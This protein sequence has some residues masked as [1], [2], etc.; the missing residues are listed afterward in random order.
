[1]NRLLV[2]LLLGGALAA[3]GGGKSNPESLCTLEVPPPAACSTACDPSGLDTCP[4]GFFCASTGKCDAQCTPTGGQCGSGNECNSNGQC[5]PAGQGCEGRGCDVADCMSMG[6]DPTTLTGT[7]L[8]PN[9]MLPLYGISVYVPAKDPG[10]FMAGVQCGSCANAFPGGSV[11]QTTTD[12]HG[13]FTLTNVPTGTDVPLIITTGKWRRIIKVSNIASCTSQAITQTDTR[14]PASSDDMTPNTTQ[15]DMPKI[16]ISTGEADEIECLMRRLGFADK[17]ITTDQQGGHIHLFTDTD[18]IG[19]DKNGNNV[20][21]AGTSSFASGFAGGTGNLSN[22]KTLWGTATDPGK[23]NNYDIVILSCEGG[24]YVV[25][26]PQEAMNHLKAYA[27]AGGRV[28]LSHWHN[29]WMEGNTQATSVGHATIKPDVWTSIA[30]FDDG[31]TKSDLNPNNIGPITDVIDTVHNPKGSAFVT[32]MDLVQTNSPMGLVTIQAKTGKHTAV[33]VDPAKG[34]QW[35]YYQ[36]DATTQ[37]TQ[38]LQFTTPNEADAGARCG[39]VVF[40]DMHVSGNP[41]PP[42]A[43]YPNECG[44]DPLSDQEKALAF[45]FF[46]ISSCVGQ[47]F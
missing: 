27:D 44:T 39:K 21:G 4:T 36:N 16:A 7:V 2:G 13:N 1:M 34:E 24:Q 15:I 47:I 28:F 40:S 11:T 3:C 31:V 25:T 37:W 42:I 6:K 26:K 30:T 9:G 14:L 18:A 32:W 19:K 33:S 38:N 41:T 23:L 43:A 29:I 8:A 10:Q 22:S 12:E 17:E 5:V 35:A 20:S 45:M 46:D